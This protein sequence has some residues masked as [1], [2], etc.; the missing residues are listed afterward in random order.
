MAKTTNKKAAP[1]FD[2]KP[3]LE[4]ISKLGGEQGA[5]AKEALKEM[6]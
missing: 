1:A 3:Y 6:K 4:R 2:P 5:I